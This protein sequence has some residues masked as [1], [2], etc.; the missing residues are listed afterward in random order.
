MRTALKTFFSLATVF[1][2]VGVT[3]HMC[4]E[5]ESSG[6]QSGVCE[7]MLGICKIKKNKQA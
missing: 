3:V 2:I 1:Y 5:N 7:Y 4:N 6:I